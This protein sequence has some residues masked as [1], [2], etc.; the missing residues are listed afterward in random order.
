MYTKGIEYKQHKMDSFAQEELWKSSMVFSTSNHFI[1]HSADYHFM[2]RIFAI[3]LYVGTS[4][5]S[6]D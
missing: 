4:P 1:F 5:S 3:F 6:G 2:R